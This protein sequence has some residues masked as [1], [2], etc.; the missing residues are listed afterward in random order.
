MDYIITNRERDY[1]W[2]NFMSVED[3]IDLL[4]KSP[5][6]GYDTETT[7]LSFAD[8]EIRAM[9]FSDEINNFIVDIESGI[10]PT[11]F[12]DLLETKELI[13]Q[14][15]QFDLC[16][17]YKHGIIPE[18]LWDTKLAEHSL[19][20]GIKVWQRDLG[21]LI[22]SYL[23]LQIDKYLQNVIHSYPINSSEAIQYMFNDVR[24]LH[25][26]K[27]AMIPILKK[28][29]VV[30]AHKLHCRFSRVA[31]YIE[32]S[33]IRQDVDRLE[34]V[35]RREE[36]IEWIKENR[37]NKWL[38]KNTSISPLEF[39]WASPKQV[40]VLL[41]NLGYDIYDS[42]E[43][44]E[45]VEIE[46]LK[47]KYT[48]DKLITNYASYKESN[49][50][51]ST[52]G[53]NWLDYPMPD[54][55]IHT[56]IK[57]LGAETGRTSCGDK[58]HGKFPNLQNIPVGSDFRQTFCPVNKNYVFINADYSQQEAV[59]M[60]DLSQDSKLLEFFLSDETDFHSYVAREVW[61]E[62]LGNLSLDEIKKNH[63]DKRQSAKALGFTLNYGGNKFAFAASAKISI[64]EAESIIN[65]YFAR[66]SGL[67]SYADEVTDNALSKGYVLIND[68]TGGKRFIQDFK[69]YKLNKYDNKS[70]RAF[71]RKVEK[72]ALNTPVQG[73]AADIS[74][75]ACILFFEW[76]IKNKLFGKVTIPLFVHDEIV[77]QCTRGKSDIV[78]KALQDCMEKA[79]SYFLKTLSLKAEPKISNLWEH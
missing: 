40:G 53:R 32:F 29:E 41:K 79:G 7:S 59:I 22:D 54:G 48:N 16:F 55:L 24:Y 58:R 67:K 35:Y 46:S 57:A 72:M 38:L 23:G 13:V 65:K 47:S 2:N 14:D 5:S 4:D 50:L 69:F 18:K 33:G 8:G 63:K 30:A 21:A 1:T 64:E 34:K 70:T 52:Y 51:V 9:L 19:S 6:I 66:F 61:H 44:K 78:S 39:S 25:K 27:K 11:L 60:A 37:L 77:A 56:K 36:A 12:K 3:C 75:T 28:Y 26:L 73:T 43:K 45:S 15:G 17:L 74:K 62:E 10:D 42:K 31:A 20:L 76:I 68:I 71:T 49:K